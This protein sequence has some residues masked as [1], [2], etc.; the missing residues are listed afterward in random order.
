MIQLLGQRFFQ[1]DLAYQPAG[2]WRPRRPPFF[3]NLG[4]ELLDGGVPG[5]LDW[6]A[7]NQFAYA[8]H[9]KTGWKKAAGG[10]AHV[11]YAPSQ[12]LQFDI[13]VKPLRLGSHVVVRDAQDFD[14]RY[15]PSSWTRAW[16]KRALLPRA[17][18]DMVP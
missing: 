15:L 2:P 3:G 14:N 11:A 5:D 1:V 7:I 17:R 4:L 18:L 13:A 16:P 6:Q 8:R 10:L 9:T 12:C